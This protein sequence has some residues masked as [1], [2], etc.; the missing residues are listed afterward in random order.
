MM[1]GKNTLRFVAVFC[2]AFLSCIT[3]FSQEIQVTAPDEVLEGEIFEV[4]YEVFSNFPMRENPEL[5]ENKNFE[6]VGKPSMRYI[7]PSPFW[8]RDYHTLQLNCKFKAKKTGKINLPQIRILIE[9]QK[10]SSDK[11]ELFVQKLPKI[12]DVKCFVELEST[13]KVAKVG[14]TLTLTYKLYSTREISG[15]I[16]FNTPP[17]TGFNLQDMTPSKQSFTEE[18]IKGITYKVYIVRKL[19]LQPTHIGTRELGDGVVEVG[20]SY[21]T[22]RII[23]DRWGRQ[24]E[25]QYEDVKEC[26]IGSLQ[27][28]VHDMVSL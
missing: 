1:G 24:Y 5:E 22:G 16:R 15:A 2:I 17:L 9:G 3:V 20:Y 14:D 25:E 6:L 26:A 13:K 4:Q 19:M 11:V 8:G 7:N 27:L 10:I 18:K 21:P 12:E 28:R 23:R